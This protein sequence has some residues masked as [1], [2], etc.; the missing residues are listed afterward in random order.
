M[1]AY[2]LQYVAWRLDGAIKPEE[3]LIGRRRTLSIFRGFLERM[4]NKLERGSTLDWKLFR[5]PVAPFQA[6]KY[7]RFFA[8]GRTLAG[9]QEGVSSRLDMFSRQSS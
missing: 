7:V 3:G 8:Q 6:A 1:R 4:M 5:D 2:T 9:P